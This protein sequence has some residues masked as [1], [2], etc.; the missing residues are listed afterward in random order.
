MLNDVTVPVVLL[1]VHCIDIA[2]RG[3]NP[4]G[5]RLEVRWTGGDQ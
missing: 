4:A 2:A 1:P 5:I 3:A